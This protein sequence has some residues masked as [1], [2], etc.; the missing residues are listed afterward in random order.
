MSIPST[1]L[2]LGF[3]I[4]GGVVALNVISPDGNTIF[5]INQSILELYDIAADTFVKADYPVFSLNLEF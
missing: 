2:V 4:I 1:I 3:L 5:E